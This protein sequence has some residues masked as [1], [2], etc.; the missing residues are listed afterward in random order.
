MRRYR[1]GVCSWSLEAATA[2]ELGERVAATG[3]RAVQLALDPIRLGYM[4]LSQVRD[5]LREA[6]AEAVS[7]M[8]AME[9]EDY[10]TLESIRATGG[11]A[12]DAPWPRN[13]AAAVELAK[14][15]QE[16]RLPLVTFHAGFIPHDAADPRRGIL[17]DRLRLLASLYRD[18][19]VQVG[20][21][22]GQETAETLEEILGALDGE[23]VGANVDPANL[24]LYGMGDP[25]AALHRL[26][27]RVIQVHIKDAL[28]AVQE[29]QW[30]TEVPVG[31]GTVDWA[32]FLAALDRCPGVTTLVIEREAGAERVRDIVHARR[33]LEAAL[34]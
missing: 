22:T 4:E 10:S 19:R 29:G 33:F 5:R 32:A 13:R 11:I 27:P 17:I 25:V 16:L 31:A 20:L 3:V 12:P 28:P 21:E 2:D 24:I 34:R 8:M 1:L 18:R 26:G 23:G 15:A 6:G 9:G 30:G 14:I 7:G